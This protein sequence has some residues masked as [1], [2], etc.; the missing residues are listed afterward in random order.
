VGRGELGDEVGR[1]R[2]RIGEGLVERFR[3]LRQEVDRVRAHDQ[4]VMV[5][6]VPV[7]DQPGLLELVER[8][9]L[10]ADRE[11]ADPVRALAGG[12]ARERGRVD[13]ARQ[14]HAHRHVGD[15]VRADRVAEPLTKLF[16]ELLLAFGA[17]AVGGDRPRT[18]I[19]SQA[20]VSAGR[21]QN[22]ARGQLPRFPEDRERRRNRVEREKGLQRV[23]VDLA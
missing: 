6:R 22:V 1:E 2:R 20:D 8:A 17:R 5:G 11:G 23:Q 18:R 9:L 13:P 14:Q 16:R 19:P 12:Q 10:E 4:L 21:D 3:E 15:E 7:R